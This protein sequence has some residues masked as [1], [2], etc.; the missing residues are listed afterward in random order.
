MLQFL[1]LTELSIY[2]CFYFIGV[3]EQGLQFFYKVTVS[4]FYTGAQHLAHVIC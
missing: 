1:D 4:Y 3:E 2:E